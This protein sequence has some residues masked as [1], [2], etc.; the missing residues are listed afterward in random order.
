MKSISANQ[1]S[2]DFAYRQAKKQMKKQELNKRSNRVTAYETSPTKS[3]DPEV[4]YWENVIE[5]G[6]S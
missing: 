4:S 6:K 1:Y 2:S 3:Y 5:D